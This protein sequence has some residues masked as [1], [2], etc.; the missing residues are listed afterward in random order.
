MEVYFDDFKVTQVKSPVV[1]SQ[2]FYPFGLSFNKFS[3]ENALPNR[4]KLFQGQ[5]HVDDLGLNWDS[6]KWR[7]HQPD[8]GRF[9]NV[10]PLSE[11]YYYNSPYAFSENRVIDGIEL[12]GLEVVLLKDSQKNAPITKT[13]NNGNYADNAKTKTIH[14]F[15]HGNTSAFFNEKG[16]KG[17]TTITTGAQL[18]KILNQSSPLWKDSKSKEGFTVVIHSCRTG[19]STTDEKGNTVPSVTQKMSGSKEMQ[20]VNL[21]AP[22]ERDFF[23]GSGSGKEMGPLVAK[24][25]DSNTGDYLPGTPKEQQGIPTNTMGNWNTFNGGQ[26]TDQHNG[27]WSPGGASFGSYEGFRNQLLGKSYEN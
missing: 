23:S 22:T 25:T 18:N 10:D 6:F 26:L 2:D 5:E 12:E 17:E 4:L 16:K 9:F 27:N 15:A 20:G 7:N 1:E 3:R 8:I 13:A 11:K 24:N 21:V 19:R 14:V